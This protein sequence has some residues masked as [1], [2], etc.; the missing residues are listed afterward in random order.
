[1]QEPI[2]HTVQE[3]ARILRVEAA[4]I[5]RSIRAGSFQRSASAAAM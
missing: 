4:T 3:S 2:F 1:M 5:Y